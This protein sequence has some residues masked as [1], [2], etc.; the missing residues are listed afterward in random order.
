MKPT[1]A[2]LLGGG[3][4]LGVCAL[5]LLHPRGLPEVLPEMVRLS[6]AQPSSAAEGPMAASEAGVPTVAADD[7]E[8]WVTGEWIV[9]PQTGVTL[10]ALAAR[11]G[12]QI[13]RSLG[14]SGAGAIGVDGVSPAEAATLGA[15]LAADAEIVEL[16]RQ[17]Y[18]YAAE[19]EIAEQTEGVATA[20]S[21]SLEGA[22]GE[23]DPATHKLR[24]LQWYLD[25]IAAPSSPPPGI[26][27]VVVAVL[28]SGVAYAA[29]PTCLG[30]GCPTP[31]PS[32]AASPSWRPPTG[33]TAT[34]CPSTSTSTA[35]T[36]P[37]SS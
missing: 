22:S 23:S 26:S 32:S 8:T 16:S 18:V 2:R 9:V 1:Y 33:W 17:A 25:A 15:A 27:T 20:G 10:E 29:D 11:H 13:R 30:L 14:R 28:D 7:D 21:L 19:D 34:P 24:K 3:A 31:A 12:L 4:L 35:P 5:A 36:S 6:G 37:A